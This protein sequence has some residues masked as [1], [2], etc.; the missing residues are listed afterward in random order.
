MSQSQDCKKLMLTRSG[1]IGHMHL[2][3][4]DTRIMNN[5]SPGTGLAGQ[6]YDRNNVMLTMSDCIVS[7]GL[8]AARQIRHRSFEAL[9]DLH[10]VTIR[11][12]TH[13]T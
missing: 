12:T 2:I 6:V 11:V 8:Y 9:Q 3:Q 1:N 5:N 13:N 4:D 7:R 10:H